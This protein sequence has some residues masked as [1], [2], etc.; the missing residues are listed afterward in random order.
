MENKRPHH[1]TAFPAPMPTCP[2][3]GNT[4]VGKRAYAIRPYMFLVGQCT[5]ETT[6]Q[7]GRPR[8]SQRAYA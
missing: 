8:A 1:R 4:Q 2:F 3:P 5:G 7:C 6:G